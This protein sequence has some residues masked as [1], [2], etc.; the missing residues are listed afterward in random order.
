[1]LMVINNSGLEPRSPGLPYILEQPIQTKKGPMGPRT[2]SV[3][4]LDRQILEGHFSLPR[5]AET[6]SVTQV[7][8]NTDLHLFYSAQK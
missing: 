8:G 7:Q 1:M 5:L 2:F 3:T 6:E 4:T